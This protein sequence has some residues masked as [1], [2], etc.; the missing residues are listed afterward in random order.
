MAIGVTAGPL[1]FAGAL[2]SGGLWLCGW[3]IFDAIATATL[4]CLASLVFAVGVITLQRWNSNGQA[5]ASG[6]LLAACLGAIFLLSSPGYLS[7]I[8]GGNIMIGGRI[9]DFL[10][11]SLSFVGLVIS[12]VMTPIV[13]V[14]VLLRWTSGGS[15]T[16]NDGTFLVIRWVGSLLIVSVGSVLIQE[17]GLTRL[18]NILAAMRM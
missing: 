17:E 9:V 4:L 16:V 1:T 6:G 15:V 11:D 10:A 18:L 14:E 2:L 12:V 7:L 13:I 5:V 8:S 3:A